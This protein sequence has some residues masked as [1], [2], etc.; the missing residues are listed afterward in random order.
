MAAD[1]RGIVDRVEALV[2]EE[3]GRNIAALFA[4]S[5]G[6]LWHAAGA[7]AAG[8]THVGLI[9]G[10]FVPGGMPPAAET[11]GPVGTALL[12]AALGAVGIPCR[13]ATDDPC[14]NACAVALDA[15]GAAAVPVDAVAPGAP[16]D[17]LI[18]AWREAGITHAVAIERCGAS[19]DG[20]PRNMRGEDIG[21]HTALLDPLFLAGPWDTVAVGDGGNEIGMG[22]LPRT[23]IASQVAEGER[24]ACTTPAHHLIVAGVSNWGAW[25]LIAALAA[26]RPE[27]RTCLLPFL[28]ANR[29]RAILEATVEKGPAVD[30]VSRRQTLTVDNFDMAIH[31]RK[32]SALRAAVETPDAV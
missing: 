1:P 27:W 29:D 17:G 2:Q 23:L 28:D 31:H 13:L 20:R 6:G 11:D 22:T 16:L 18:A 4:A 3:V 30:G 25:A 5:R 12:A 32:L 26:F 19:A 21:A 15:A 9:T 10:F 24:I 7:L 8:P 14:R